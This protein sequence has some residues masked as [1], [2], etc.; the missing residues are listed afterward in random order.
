[1]RL[2]KKREDGKARPLLVQFSDGR[3]KNLVIENA[4]RLSKAKEKHE[5]VT[6]SHDMTSKEREQCRKLVAETKQKQTDDD[7]GGG[8]IHMQYKVRGPQGK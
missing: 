3:V 8:G 6:I 1:M 2:R 4:G 7:S 5:N